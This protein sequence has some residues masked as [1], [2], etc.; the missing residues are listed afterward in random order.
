MKFNFRKIASVIA[1]AVMIG[2][3]A[4]TALAANYPSPM[5]VGG[6]ADAAIVVTA[7]S[8]AGAVSDWDAAVSLQ[9]ALQ[10]KVTTATSG[11]TTTATGGDS[12]KIER[13][14]NK[15][16]LNDALTDVQTTKISDSD[17]PNLLADKTFR[18]KDNIDYK[19][20]QEIEI[21]KDTA[22]NFTHFDDNDYK[23]DT[24]T[25]GIKIGSSVLVMNYT[26]DFTKDVRSDVDSSGRLEDM[27]DR[28]ITILGKT[29][30]LLNAYNKS[31]DTK[32]ELMKGASSSTININEEKTMAI[33]DK[34][35]TI[36]L[37]YVD[38]T[39]S[40]FDVIDSGGTS[41]TTTKLAKGG[42]YKLSDG[43]QL[44]VTDISYQA[45]AGGVMSAEFTIGADKLTLE[46]NQ[47][48]EV[49][50]VD[51]DE[52]KVF[53]ARSEA[54]SNKVDIQKIVLQWISDDEI[55]ISDEMEAVFPAFESVKITAGEVTKP[56]EEVIEIKSQGTYG[57]ELTVP[58]KDGDANINILYGNG[59]DYLYVAGDN[60]GTSTLR[61]GNDTGGDFIRYDRDT[62]D[63]F[64]ASWNSSTEAESYLLRVS[65][66]SDS[67]G[68]NYTTIENKLTGS[69]YENKKD[70]DIVTIGNVELTILHV[71]HGLDANSVDKFVDIAAG[72]GVTFNR[73]YTAG[74]LGIW[75]PI[76]ST[77]G[78]DCDP[79]QYGASSNNWGVLI[80]GSDAGSLVAQTTNRTSSW[81]LMMSEEDKDGNIG[82][83]SLINV[84]LGWSSSEAQV[85]EVTPDT[86]G[87]GGFFYSD[88]AY[89]E[90]GTTN[91]YE[92]YVA[93][94]LGT[95]VLFR[96]PT[97]G[98]KSAEITYHCS[99]MY[100]NIFVTAPEASIEAG[101]SSSGGGTVVVVKDNEVSSMSGNNLVVVGGSC[102]NAA[103]AKILGSDTPLC[104]ED[105]TAKTNVDAGKYLIKAVA[106]PYNS[107][108]VA[109]LVA[110]YEAAETK[111]A[112]A[113]LKE[114]H[115]TDIG[116]EAVYPQ[117]AA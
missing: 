3:T 96:K 85:T 56:C 23:K 13:S 47:V 50:D 103:A 1:S 29:Y 10:G 112:V 37:T 66:T 27:E 58:I 90:I 109:V 53:I 4:G 67:D 38:S 54:D 86:A 69:K 62:D 92:G 87:N 63:Y 65:S 21:L 94:D 81:M 59:T 77:S 57:I 48:L 89:R 11:T 30:K 104:G 95:K 17:L 100:A 26:L 64:I 19:Y 110:G 8:H 113:K 70:G 80:N 107:A 49:N 60:D 18:S 39:Y 101:T 9:S 36:T 45:L 32:F 41:Q 73:I 43:T 98:A 78:D 14:T 40:Q 115:A 114:S 68:T 82:S 51:V 61:T 76:N 46:N 15:L 31:S 55:F 25:L 105:F 20:E 16:N 84:T 79:L 52:I 44:G 35:Y 2:S 75:L 34:S 72:S 97:S 28:D 5:V 108:K 116:T 99:Q 42:T 102:I 93:S 74:G 22:I 12:I 111:L 88:G 6:T 24:P 7:G 106:S 117:T 91:E 71:S 83:G 33:D